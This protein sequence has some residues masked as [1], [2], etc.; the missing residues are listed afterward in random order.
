M[1]RAV[2][3]VVLTT[4]LLVVVLAW[5]AGRDDEPGRTAAPSPTVT[6]TA[7]PSDPAKRVAAGT[8][9]TRRP[10]CVSHAP[11]PFRPVSLSAA[12]VTRD[13][14]VLALPR[15]ALGVPG[16]PPIS[17]AGK[18]AFGW[19]EPG[20]AP[21]ALRGNVI[22]T[23]HTWPDGSAMGNF[24]LARFH[25]RDLLTLH[26]AGGERLCYR[27]TDRVEVPFDAPGDRVY[28]KD[29]PPRMVIVACSG[30]RL[31]PGEWT[32]RTLWFLE[33]VRQAFA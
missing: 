16:V 22:M 10:I 6:P 30:T 15:D 12:H 2:T 19:D 27:V 18:I 17:D 11:R 20:I 14:P 9:I 32:H 33:P 26:G 24:L 29:G 25:E 4:A 3:A 23:A 21:G 13:V 5:V 7:T 8:V 31:G 1:R 28:Q